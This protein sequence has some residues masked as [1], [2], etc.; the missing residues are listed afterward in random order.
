MFATILYITW[1]VI[2]FI[3]F[4]SLKHFCSHF[5]SIDLLASKS[6]FIFWYNIYCGISYRNFAYM[7]QNESEFKEPMCSNMVDYCDLSIVDTTRT[8]TPNTL[9]LLTFNRTFNVAVHKWFGFCFSC[10]KQ[11]INTILQ[12]TLLKIGQRVGQQPRVSLILCSNEL[13]AGT[14]ERFGILWIILW[15]RKCHR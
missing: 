6:S 14:S 5:E 13:L 15:K 10:L 4:S 1:I 12:I 7:W 3:F 8:P 11:K 9:S 2:F